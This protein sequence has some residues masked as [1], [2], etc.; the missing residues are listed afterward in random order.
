MICVA[1]LD[2]GTHRVAQS[3]LPDVAPAPQSLRPRAN[4]Q[5]LHA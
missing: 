1:A 5:D 4:G 3:T 2:H